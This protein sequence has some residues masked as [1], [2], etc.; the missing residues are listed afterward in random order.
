MQYNVPP[1]LEALVKKRLA[2]GAF[3]DVEDVFRCALDAQVPDSDWP[4]Q[5]LHALSAH[6]EEGF[7]QAERGELI[8]GDQ[9]RREIQTM[10]D[11]WLQER[12]SKSG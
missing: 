9:A 8:D 6:V 1:D 7:L 10:K 11:K 3:A 2:T 12:A 5:G 4:E